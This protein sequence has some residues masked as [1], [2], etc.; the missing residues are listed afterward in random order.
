[1]TYDDLLEIF[2]ENHNP[3]FGAWS[4]Q[5]MAAVFCHDEKQKQA[6]EKSRERLASNLNREIKTQIL[7]CTGFYLAEDY[8]QKYTLSRHSELMKEFRAMYPT[9]QGLISST[10]AARVNGYLAGYV[11]C[12]RLQADIDALGLS[13]RSAKRL[14]TMVCGREVAATCTIEE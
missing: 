10:A 8:H 9:T 7:P 14:L 4:R 11:G 12:D 2:W 3:E 13:E 5:Y 1:M 6:A